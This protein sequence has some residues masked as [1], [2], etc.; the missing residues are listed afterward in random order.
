M[1]SGKYLLDQAYEEVEMLGFRLSAQKPPEAHQVA[2][3]VISRYEHIFEIDPALMQEHVRQQDIP[4]WDFHRIVANRWEH[5]A[6]M[7]D[8]FADSVLSGEEL[9][10]RSR[11]SGRSA[12]TRVAGS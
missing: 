12:L 1:N 7:H 6:W 9:R 8:H 3:G 10:R 4:E 2:D 5:L 11:R